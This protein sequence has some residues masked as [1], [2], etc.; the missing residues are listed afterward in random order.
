MNKKSIITWI[1]SVVLFSVLFWYTLV[2]AWTWIFNN[3][4]KIVFKLSDNVFLD[5]IYLNKTQIMFESWKNLSKYEIKS[6]C[7]IYSNLKYK[8]DNFYLFE[9][10]FFNNDCENQNL[11]LVNE[12]N[13]IENRFSLN[14]VREYDALSNLLDIKT[15]DLILYKKILDKK[16]S[17]YKK[18]EKYNKSIEKNYYTFLYKKRL[19]K[20]SEYNANL[21]KNILDKRWEKYLIPVDW[22]KIDLS[23]SKIPNAWR[24]YRSSYTDW[25]HHWW[26]S[27]WKFWDLLVSLD[28][29]IVVRVISNFNYSNLDNIKYWKKLSIKEKSRNLDILRWNQ[30]WLKTM[31]WDVVFYSHLN[32]VFTN[33][34][35]WEVIKKGQ[36]LWTIW[37]TGV[38]D[39]NYN[40]YHLHFSIQV[41][42]FMKKMI[43][44]NDIDDYMGWDWL[45]KNKSNEYI[46]KNWNNI[47]EI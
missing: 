16:V 19:L 45:F 14:I 5:S 42:P 24:P 36:P 40:D 27:A 41:N 10:K 35:V 6:S 29:A 9:I 8:K 30:V 13:E 22:W 17:L 26:D 7:N 32:E 21:L 37:I 25:I 33:I 46:L 39:K 43:W 38:P 1:I 4:T 15:E 47:F 11:I 28:D 23:H 20:E 3:A 18:Y 2:Y 12:K 44:K 31:K 34:K